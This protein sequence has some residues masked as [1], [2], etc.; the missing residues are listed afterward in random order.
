MLQKCDKGN[1]LKMKSVIHKYIQDMHKISS[2]GKSALPGPAPRGAPRAGAGPALRP[3]R[4]LVVRV[5]LVYICMAV[6][7]LFV[8]YNF[9]QIAPQSAGTKNIYQKYIQI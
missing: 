8:A 4:R 7:H 1:P 2:G 5:H 3:R 9:I 6:S